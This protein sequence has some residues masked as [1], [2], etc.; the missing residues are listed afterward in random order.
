MTTEPAMDD[1][2]T[3]LTSADLH[4]LL[5]LRALCAAADDAGWVSAER[6]RRDVELALSRG[7][8]LLTDSAPLAPQGMG[9][10]QSER[11]RVLAALAE[12]GF[13]VPEPAPGVDRDPAGAAA[14]GPL[15]WERVRL[16][17][18]LREGDPAV[19]LRRLDQ[20]IEPEL[21]SRPEEAPR[22]A[23]LPHGSTLTARGLVKIYR[24]QAS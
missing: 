21:G 24:T 2:E 9:P 6:A 18:A 7:E 15:A 23:A 13:I 20:R 8:V 3:S 11:D 16:A 12:S 4:T 1:L 22:S 14:E 19:L 17:P 10:T 5:G